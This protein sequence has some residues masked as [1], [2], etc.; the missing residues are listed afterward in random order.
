VPSQDPTALA[1][2]IRDLA[3]NPILAKKYSTTGRNRIETS[4]NSRI[5]ALELKRLLEL[6]LGRRDHP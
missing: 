1:I 2:S 4:F 6:T 3:A 5:S